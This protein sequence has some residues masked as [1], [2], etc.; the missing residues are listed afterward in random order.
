MT[1]Q[2][3]HMNK[4]SCPVTPD[5]RRLSLYATRYMAHNVAYYKAKKKKKSEAYESEIPLLGIYPKELKS[6]S[7]REISTAILRAAP[8]RVAKM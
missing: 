2:Q 4:R 5:R 7:Q 8:F 3:I 1:E 6:G